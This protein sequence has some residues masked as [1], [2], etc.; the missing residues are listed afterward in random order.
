LAHRFKGSAG[1]VGTQ[2]LHSYFAM[3]QQ[4]LDQPSLSESEFG[5]M[6]SAGQKAQAFIAE[7]KGT[8]KKI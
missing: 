5:E 7:T 6:F 8:L 1:S 4:V 2:K 3:I